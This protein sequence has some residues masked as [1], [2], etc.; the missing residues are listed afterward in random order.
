[1]DEGQEYAIR[2]RADPNGKHEKSL[3][4]QQFET[5]N[6]VTTSVYT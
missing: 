4:H 3:T 2:R 5:S 6:E 1:M